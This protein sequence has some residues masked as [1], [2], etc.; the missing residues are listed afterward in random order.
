[1]RTRSDSQERPDALEG[2]R[3][4]MGLSTCNL[5][6]CCRQVVHTVQHIFSCPA[7]PTEL[8]QLDL[9]IRPVAVVEFLRT[10]P[11]INL[12]EE[13]RP[14]PKPPSA[15]THNFGEDPMSKKKLHLMVDPLN[16]GVNCSSCIWV[17]CGFP[18]GQNDF[19]IFHKTNS[20]KD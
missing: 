16:M 1:M 14:Q 3:H 17:L 10:L 20:S 13:E 9:W 11:F 7:Y 5:C 19:L 4:R 2:N 18:V 6:T 8:N 15:V 12:L